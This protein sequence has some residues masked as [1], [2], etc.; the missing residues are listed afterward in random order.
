MLWV[1]SDDGVDALL[2]D[3]IA[4]C[5]SR[6]KESLFCSFWVS[7][8]VLSTTY[9]SLSKSRM[10]AFAYFRHAY[11]TRITSPEVH[12]QKFP[13]FPA[14]FFGKLALNLVAMTPLSTWPDLTTAVLV[15]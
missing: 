10:M 1:Y 6:E 11:L 8:F 3:G 13:R 9:S 12:H 14:S 5:G 4:L 15:L 2:L 7:C